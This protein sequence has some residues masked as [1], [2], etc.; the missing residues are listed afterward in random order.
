MI[1]VWFVV[2]APA[3]AVKVTLVFPEVT[4]TDAG[5]L[6]EPLLLESETAAPP[7]G[8]AC[9]NV[10]VHGVLLLG[11]RLAPVQVTELRTAG[12]VNEMVTVCELL[13]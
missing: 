8:A 12:G 9:D 4:V 13:L 5:T 3:V 2:K 1:A 10:A 6:R 7:L 11:P